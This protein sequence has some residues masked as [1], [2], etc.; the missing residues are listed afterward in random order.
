MVSCKKDPVSEPNDSPKSEVYAGVYDSSFSYHEFMPPHEISI[1]WDNKG[2]YGAGHDTLD[3]D[4]NGTPDLFIALYTLNQD[5]LH[6]ITGMP[7]PYPS[8]VLHGENGLEIALYSESYATG[9]GQTATAIFADRLDFNERIDEISDWKKVLKMWSENPGGAG[10]PPFGDWY[11]ASAESYLAFRM[12]GNKFG[13]IEVDASDAQDP[14]FI[15]YAFQ[16][17]LVLGK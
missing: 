5:S 1:V 2:L 6:L 17:S 8:C 4:S 7:N 3:L 12:D 16:N 15:R 13:W 9:L 14:K 11:N 10:M